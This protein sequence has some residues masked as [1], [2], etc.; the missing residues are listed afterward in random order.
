MISL[1]LSVHYIKRMGSIEQFSVFRIDNVFWSNAMRPS[2]QSTELE[3]GNVGGDPFLLSS[4]V[5]NITSLWW[6]YR[7]VTNCRPTLGRF[8]FLFF[9]SFLFWY[10]LQIL[11]VTNNQKQCRA[12]QFLLAILIIFWLHLKIPWLS[13]SFGIISALESIE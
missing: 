4:F 10:W 13:L 5:P 6:W 9:F 8:F 1:P 7:V 3:W 11:F 2:Q 12:A